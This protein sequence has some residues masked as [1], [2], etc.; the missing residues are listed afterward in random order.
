MEKGANSGCDFQPAGSFRRNLPSAGP[1]TLLCTVQENAND[2]V[3]TGTAPAAGET[4]TEIAGATIRGCGTIP[5]VEMRWLACTTWE[6]CSV[7]PRYV[8]LTVAES[9]YGAR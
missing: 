1:F 5:I 3:P 6:R 9:G 2:F 8:T 4:V 7:A